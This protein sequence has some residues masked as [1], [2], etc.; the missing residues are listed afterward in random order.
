MLNIQ[1]RTIYNH[2]NLDVLKGINSSCIDLLY[3]DPPFNTKKEF[4]A[5]IG[6]SAEGGG[7]K[8]W[9]KEEDVK[10][11]WLQTIKE[12][13]D[14]LYNFLSGVKALSSIH[15]SKANKYYLYNYCY[16]SYMAIRLIE[17]HR[18][19]KNTGS[20][21]LHCDPTM[22]HYL[23]I[24]M[25]IIFGEKNFR[26]EIVWCYRGAGYPKKDFGK[27][28]DVIYRYSKSD[29]YFLNIDDVREEYAEATKKRFKHYIGNK[30]KGLDFGEQSLNPK[31]KHPDDWWQI[32]PIAPSAKERTGWSTQKPL[33]LLERIIKAS[34]NEG[35]LVLDAFCGCATTCIVAERLGR[36]WVGIDISIKAYD[37]VRRRIKTEFQ[38]KSLTDFSKDLNEIDEIITNNFKTT[39][40]NRTDG[41]QV[42]KEE[43]YVY[44]ITHPNYEGMYKVGIAKD[45]KSRLN[46]YQTSDPLRQYKLIYQKKTENY[47]EIETYIHKKYKALGEWV[48]GDLPDI[49]T[50]IENF[51]TQN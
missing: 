49:K 2:D 28:H 4:T 39:P 32:Q 37:L 48:S 29:D 17:L 45:Y 18:I 1:N 11:E 19:L 21:Y 31:G 30:R 47:R 40:P 43:K 3:I 41:G 5:P 42:Y 22:S 26:N 8:D 24:L 13:Y 6:S 23:K 7:F 44:I 16:L 14:G 10:D 25:D 38:N 12:D 50:D 9:F 51:K 35:D 34:S 27:R 36:Q 33:K 15:S 46:S 20:I